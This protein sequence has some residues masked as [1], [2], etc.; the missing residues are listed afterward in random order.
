MGGEGR[1]AAFQNLSKFH[2]EH[3]KFYAET[4]LHDAARMHEFSKTLKTL[5]DRWSVQEPS[6]G[7][8]GN[9]YAGC[10]DLNETSTIQH[11]GLLFMEGEGEPQEITRLKR[12]L[13]TMADDYQK[14]GEWLSKAMESSWEVAGS[15][16][17]DPGMAAVLGDRHRIIAN[18]W[19]AAD[20]SRGIS[21]L[22]RRALETVGSMDFTPGS[23]REDLEGPRT[24]PG[25]LY[26]SAEMID[27]AADLAAESAALVHENEYRWRRFRGRL[28][29]L[30]STRERQRE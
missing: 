19:L 18:D 15:L 30:A 21:R 14:T 12:D 25:Y 17:K 20:M 26:S 22:L 23:I 6:R 11:D 27:R 29:E 2:R 1:Y 8:G 24:S 10:E 9:R 5:A 16:A 4:P 7:D 28:A 3:E 13:S